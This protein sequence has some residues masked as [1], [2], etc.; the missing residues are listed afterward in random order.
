MKMKINFISIFLIIYYLIDPDFIL[1]Y[2]KKNFE[3]CG[4]AGDDKRVIRLRLHGEI[5]RPDSLVLMLSY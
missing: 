2:R 3:I 5:Y 1:L 4:Y